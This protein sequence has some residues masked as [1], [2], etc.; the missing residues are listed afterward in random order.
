MTSCQENKELSAQFF[1]SNLSHEIRT[2]LNGIVGYTQLL[3]QTKL[4]NTQ[5]MYINSMNHCCIQLVELVN[6]ILDFSKLTTGKPQINN[7]CFSFNEI[8][9]EVNSAIGYRI[10]EKKQ[11]CRYVI[12]KDL[13]EY[14]VSDKQKIIQV[15]IN[16]VSN[17][18][19]FTP[20]NGRIIITISSKEKD[21][22]VCTV[23]DD[24]VG[25]SLEDQK[26]LFNPFVQVQESLTKNGSGL[27]L[28][29]SK[30]LIEILGGNIS[31]ESDKGQ[32]TI[33]TFTIKY[34]HYEDFQKV[35]EKH[36]G[37]LKNKYILIVDD[38]V[39]NR[40]LLGETLF[41][42]GTTPVICS[43]AKETLRMVSGKR[44]SFALALLDIC[45]PD[46]SGTSLA[47]YLKN[48][49][50]ELPLVALSSLDDTFDTSNFEYVLPK[51]V[52]KVK[53]LDTLLKTIE[54]N[55]IK[56]Y[57]LNK[58]EENIVPQSCPLPIRR[59]SSEDC[60]VIKKDIRFLIAEDISYNSELLVKMLNGMGYKNIDTSGD[61]DDAIKKL[62]TSYNNGM[63]YD[64]LLLDLKM[65]KV[66]GFGVAKHIVT[67]GY[68]YPKV[69]VITASVL[70]NDK[71]M[72]RNM[73][74]KYFLLKPFNMSH[75]KSV[76]T[77]ILNG[78]GNF[79]P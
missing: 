34:E 56:Q 17:A 3:L 12:D 9:E 72:C 10:K 62:D 48:I 19:K 63:P 2:P 76:I 32:G 37:T 21:I 44:Y 67:K 31:V 23:E 7:E 8:I 27:G 78:S 75:L 77:R 16:L 1:L 43:S 61:G 65:P 71:E 55:D 39:D 42:Y 30:K 70:D 26:K 45:M 15:F 4:D 35:I 50:P 41:E 53:L 14:I 33:F 73:G 60:N 18:N 5:Q 59:I 51:P 79:K 11:K 64:I 20:V 38:N 57:Q 13:P 36:K 52:N 24:G 40:L 74:I 68:T 6:D 66:D 58:V 54:K 69:C 29:I 49:E 25:I 47:K 22:F 28:A 46:M